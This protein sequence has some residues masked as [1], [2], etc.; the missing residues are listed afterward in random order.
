[1]GSPTTTATK[2]AGLTLINVDAVTSLTVLATP[3]A[4]NN[5][6]SLTMRETE[7]NIIKKIP[8]IHFSIIIEVDERFLGRR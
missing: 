4:E 8:L 7:Q 5:I 6:L 2:G 3:V 1:M